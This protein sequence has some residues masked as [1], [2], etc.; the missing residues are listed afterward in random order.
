MMQLFDDIDILA[1]LE[2]DVSLG[3]ASLALASRLI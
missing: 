2:R 1:V 3:R